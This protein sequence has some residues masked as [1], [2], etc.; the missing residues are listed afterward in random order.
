MGREGGDPRN[1]WCHNRQKTAPKG[2]NKK[3]TFCCKNCGELVFRFFVF[4]KMVLVHLNLVFLF[5]MERWE[6]IFWPRL[7]GRHL[8]EK[9]ILTTLSLPPLL[10]P[11]TSG[12]GG[13]DSIL[14]P[15]I[16]KYLFLLFPF[17]R[18]NGK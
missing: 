4:W 7:R 18:D 14:T 8:E 12:Q 13:G 11:L 15:V 1:L 3:I 10:L 16:E 9:K 6:K 5:G 2:R 17:F